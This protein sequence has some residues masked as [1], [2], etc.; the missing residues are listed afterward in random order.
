MQRSSNKFLLRGNLKPRGVLL[1]L[2]LMGAINGFDAL[3]FLD[4]KYPS[5]DGSLLHLV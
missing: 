3:W 2:W 5:I 1:Y 4:L